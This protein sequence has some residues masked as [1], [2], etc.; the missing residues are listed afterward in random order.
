LGLCSSHF[1]CIKGR[2]LQR[3]IAGNAEE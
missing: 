1:L 3:S 2:N